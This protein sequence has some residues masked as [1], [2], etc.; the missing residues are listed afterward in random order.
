MISPFEGRKYRDVLQRYPSWM[1]FGD[2]LRGFFKELSKDL[3]MAEDYHRG[4]YMNSFLPSANGAAPATTYLSNIDLPIASISGV[5]SNPIS[6][7][8]GI[9]RAYEKNELFTN[10]PTRVSFV[11]LD[12]ISGEIPPSSGEA[13]CYVQG[14][15]LSGLYYYSRVGDPSL[16]LLNENYEIVASGEFSRRHVSEPLEFIPVTGEWYRAMLSHEPDTDVSFFDI[17]NPE[18][19]VELDHSGTYVEA[20]KDIISH[21]GQIR[22]RYSYRDFDSIHRI[23]AETM[24]WNIGTQIVDPVMVVEPS[25]PVRVSV[26]FALTPPSGTV[27]LAADCT[28]LRPGEC[29]IVDFSYHTHVHHVESSSGVYQY[30]SDSADQDSLRI[31]SAGGLGRSV[32]YN[33]TTGNIYGNN[34]AG[35]MALRRITDEH[36]AELGDGL[37]TVYNEDATGAGPFYVTYS[38]RQTK[39]YYIFASQSY[40]ACTIPEPPNYALDY[41]LVDE[42]LIPASILSI[43]DSDLELQSL[44]RSAP[45]SDF[46]VSIIRGRKGICYDSELGNVWI[47]QDNDILYNLAADMKY[48]MQPRAAVYTYLRSDVALDG[49]A[50]TGSYWYRRAKLMDFEEPDQAYLFRSM[51]LYDE[52]IAILGERNSEYFIVLCS[53]FNP[54]QFI[55][56]PVVGSTFIP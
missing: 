21:V 36:G 26:Q 30:P 44:L 33:T 42:V 19:P 31:F 20:S 10:P 43:S 8:I 13:L 15:A 23:T 47:L 4:T 22:A 39:R 52:Y 48:Y 7:E 29:A 24:S 27:L 49:W 32:Y 25:D 54:S 17:Y 14:S 34:V 28:D 3:F 40:V 12:D 50:K 51:V 45:L 55:V 56:L 2:S 46:Q 5:Y 53:R 37:F 1:V 16:Y 41:T 6:G 38:E 9:T 18:A 35:T 11:R